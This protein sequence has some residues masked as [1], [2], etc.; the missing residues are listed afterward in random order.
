MLVVPI[1]ALMENKNNNNK[2]HY[3][4]TTKYTKTIS[5]IK[6]VSIIRLQPNTQVLTREPN[7]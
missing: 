7:Q 2:T 6:I 3:V 5:G 1:A 4:Y